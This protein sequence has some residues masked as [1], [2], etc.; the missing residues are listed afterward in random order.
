MH[1]Y[2]GQLR[3]DNIQDHTPTK[4]SWDKE[5]DQLHPQKQDPPYDPK[6]PRHEDKYPQE[7]YPQERFPQE[8][9]PQEKYQNHEPRY[10]TKFDKSELSYY[11]SQGSRVIYDY[12]HSE[13]PSTRSQAYLPD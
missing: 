8:R 11:Q 4:S 3:R 13:K 5:R 10:D 12:D 6:P 7:K 2:K 1:N 9:Y